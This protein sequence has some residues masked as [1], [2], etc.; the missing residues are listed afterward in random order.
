SASSFSPPASISLTVNG[1][2]VCV[3]GITPNTVDL[4]AAPGS[5][6]LTG[7]GFADAGFGLP[8]VNFTRGGVLLG[9]VRATALTGG[10]TTLTVPFPTNQNSL[11]GVLPGLSPGRAEERR[12]GQARGRRWWP[13][14]ST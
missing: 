1:C 14:G 11:S 12:L 7:G 10:G 2:T 8:V 9:Q 6:T 4:G 13:R 5:F 3:M